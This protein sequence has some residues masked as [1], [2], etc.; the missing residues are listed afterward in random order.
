[1]LKDITNPLNNI[2]Q[3]S[4]DAL[5]FMAQGDIP[6]TKIALQAMTFRILKFFI[7]SPKEPDIFA[8]TIHGY[9]KDNQLKRIIQHC[10]SHYGQHE[11]P[12]I[13]LLHIPIYYNTPRTLE[14]LLVDLK[15][16]VTCL[17]KAQCNALHI[18]ALENRSEIAQ[19]LIDH[20]VDK[21]ALDHAQQTPLYLCAGKNHIETARVLIQNGANIDAQNTPKRV[22][23]LHI[24]AASSHEKFV[25]LLLTYNA[26]QHI[27]D[28]DKNT[29]LHFAA[30]NN[31]E[32]I[33]SLF[34]EQSTPAPVEKK[35]ALGQTPLHAASYKNSCRSIFLLH[36]HLANI[37]TVDKDGKT[38]LQTAL[39]VLAIGAAS[40]LFNLGAN[41]CTMNN[42]QE[43]ALEIAQRTRTLLHQVPFLPERNFCAEEVNAIIFGALA[44]RASIL[45]RMVQNI[46]S[47]P[48]G[49]EFRF[50]VLPAD[51]YPASF[52]PMASVATKPCN[53]GKIE[54]TLQE[55]LRQK[56]KKI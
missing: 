31:S 27:I 18:A 36:S 39:E 55:A 9:F 35:N 37:E 38:P 12:T 19:L 47:I 29:P 43:S 30:V 24:A 54:A 1:M 8:Q 4:E 41:T 34:L 13:P 25:E 14:M 11:A 53:A 7:K 21:N 40:L 50:D 26:N 49:S 33:V 23:S 46:T 15:A 17:D 20:G 56:P 10:I 6:S 45:K 52:T 3:L 28:S 51:F 44:D 2:F 48:D 32:Y 5:A 16:P 22:T 42:K